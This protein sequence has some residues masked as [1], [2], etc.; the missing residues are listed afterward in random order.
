MATYFLVQELRTCV[1]TCPVS[2][3]QDGSI[4]SKCDSNCLDC[5]NSATA[6]T[7]CGTGMY[8][9]QQECIQECPALYYGD[10]IDSQCKNCQS[11]CS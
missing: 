10:N 11:P 5:E 8:L 6:C 3:F 9:H 2:Y 7:K 1:Q 4:C